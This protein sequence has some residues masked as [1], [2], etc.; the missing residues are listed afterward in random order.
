[1]FR[2][3]SQEKRS[4]FNDIQ[5]EAEVAHRVAAASAKQNVPFSDGEF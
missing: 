2:R 3:F 5:Q 4:V 1:M